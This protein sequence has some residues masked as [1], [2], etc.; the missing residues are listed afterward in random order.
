LTHIYFTG[1]Y[2]YRSKGSNHADP[3]LTLYHVI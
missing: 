3:C 1:C 2:C